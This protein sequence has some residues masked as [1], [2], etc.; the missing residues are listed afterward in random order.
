MKDLDS[1]K[2]KLSIKEYR[3]LSQQVL[4]KINDERYLTMII[5]D[6][7]LLVLAKTGNRPAGDLYLKDINSDVGIEM[8]WRAFSRVK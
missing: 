1:Y 6:N 8:R 2:S 3:R 5:I 7:F 4:T